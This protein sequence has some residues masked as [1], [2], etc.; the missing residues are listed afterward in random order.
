MYGRVCVCFLV[1]LFS[2]FTY[3][4]H[5]VTKNF[6]TFEQN[7]ELRI[8]WTFRFWYFP[9]PPQLLYE[10]D[11]T[12]CESMCALNFFLFILLSFP[13]ISVPG[14]WSGL[15][16]NVSQTIFTAWHKVYP[17]YVII[18]LVLFYFDS[19]FVLFFPKAYYF[20]QFRYSDIFGTFNFRSYDIFKY[21]NGSDASAAK[22]K[23]Y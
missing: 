19:C 1:H 12:G 8:I 10:T 4:H 5:F 14:I 13:F 18:A 17:F 3:V 22:C 16:I 21:L 2:H 15:N 23:M 11:S 20:N 6:V 9:P 7:D